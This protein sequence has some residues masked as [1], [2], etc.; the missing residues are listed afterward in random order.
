[1]EQ[2][3]LKRGDVVRRSIAG[4]RGFYYPDLGGRAIMVREDC[5]VERQTGWN[6]C[7]NFI[8]CSAPATAFAEKDRYDLDT[9]KMIV[10][11]CTDG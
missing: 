6:S 4:A 1:M 3:N 7:S 10:W 9:S 2:I 8:P 5:T 11:V